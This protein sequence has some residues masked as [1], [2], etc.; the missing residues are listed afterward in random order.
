[1]Q[2]LENEPE[3][4]EKL[5]EVPVAVIEKFGADLANYAAA[6]APIRTGSRV[7]GMTVRDVLTATTLSVNAATVINAA[8]GAAGSI[9][10]S[11]GVSRRIPLLRAINLVTSKPASDMALAAPTA[12]GQMLT[13]TP[14]RGRAIV[15]T[16]QSKT[17]VEPDA[18]AVTGA[19][20]DNFIAAANEAFPALRLT[21][22]DVTLVHRGIVPAVEN[23]GK[24]GPGLLSIPAVYDH[25]SEGA[26]GAITVVGIRY[27]TA[28]RVAQDVVDRVAKGLGK[29]LKPSRTATT[30]LPGAG[31]AESR[32]PGN[33]DRSQVQPRTAADDDQAPDRALCRARGRHRAPHA[34][35]SRFARPCHRDC[36]HARRRDRPRHPARDGHPPD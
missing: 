9:M 19:E 23:G 22:D 35:T 36:D 18:T 28:R 6:V 17:L 24:G 30:T 1:M 27:T 34:R 8:G 11:F 12:S 15:G 32:G 16:G 4:T 7:S 3:L 5:G 33:R 14:W 2:L 31:I 10:Q 13:L 26:A 20:V 25:A 21:R 29:R